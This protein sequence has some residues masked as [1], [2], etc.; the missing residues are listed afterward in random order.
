M[1][2]EI[3]KNTDIAKEQYQKLDKDYGFNKIAVMRWD[4]P[5]ISG[6]SD[7]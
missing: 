6:V 2:T 1:Q 3:T 4:L 7:S 5:L